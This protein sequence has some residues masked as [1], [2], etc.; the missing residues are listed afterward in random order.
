MPSDMR[1]WEHVRSLCGS[2]SG[3][4]CVE[5]VIEGQLVLVRVVGELDSVTSGTLNATLVDAEAAV[6]PPA[7]VVVDLTG[8]S[9]LGVAGL[10]V[11]VDHH[12]RCLALGSA[13]LIVPGSRAV[14]RAMAV[15]GMH[16]RLALIP[17]P[18]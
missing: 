14:R 9:F 10:S 3:E 13:L 7:P 5:Q 17:A 12:E 8:V 4:L 11:L 15:T 1:S 16:A 2:S 6:S 18:R